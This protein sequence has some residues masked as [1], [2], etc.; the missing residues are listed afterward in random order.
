MFMF[1]SRMVSPTCSSWY[2]GLVD[3]NQTLSVLAFKV[4]LKL[5]GSLKVVL[6][7]NPCFSLTLLLIFNS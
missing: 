4:R 5:S 1:L 7:E 2:Y 3:V 6:L